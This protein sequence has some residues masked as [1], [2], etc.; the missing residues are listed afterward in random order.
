[1]D[2]TVLEPL[3]TKYGAGEIVLAIATEDS[4]TVQLIEVAPMTRT[5]S[6]FAFA[7]STF[8]ADADAVAEKV[9]EG[10]KERN[11]VDFGTRGRLVADVQFDSLE[12]WARVRTQL[13]AVR[14]VAGIDIVGI[15][16][17]EAVID[18]SYFGRVEQ[19]RDALSQQNLVLAGP[20]SAYS[21]Q[22]GRASAA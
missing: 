19:F 6:A 15:A 21:I 20:P 4:N 17:N 18:V 2:W 1:A 14:S 22:I 3:A 13:R 12:Q 9:I 5:A 7:Q 10:W 8:K 16:S 11:S